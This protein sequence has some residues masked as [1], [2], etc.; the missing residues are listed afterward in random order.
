[1]SE[2][3][4]SGKYEFGVTYQVKLLRLIS[5]SKEF[6]TS[7]RPILNPRYFT[8]DV[9][10]DISRLQL[11]YFDSRREV[12]TVAAMEVAV[13]DMLAQDRQRQKKEAEFVK[14]LESIQNASLEEQSDVI[15]RAIAFAQESAVAL[16]LLES[17]DDVDRG[18][19]GSVIPRLREA[20]SVGQDL[21]NIGSIYFE[22]KDRFSWSRNAVSV[23]TGLETL[24]RHLDGGLATHELGVIVG[25][26][27]AF[28][29]GTLQNLCASAL[30]QGCLCAYATLELQTFAVEKRMDK[31]LSRKFKGL[32][33]ELLRNEAYLEK[34]QDY[35]RRVRANLVTNRWPPN[36]LTVNG[37]RAWLTLLKDRGLFGRSG[38][39]SVLFVDYAKLLKPEGRFEKDTAAV[40]SLYQGCIQIASEFDCAVWTAIQANRPAV[41]RQRGGGRGNSGAKLIHKDDLAEC[42]AVAADS[43]VIISINQDLDEKTD[44]KMRLF[45][46]KVREAED[47]RVIP[48]KVNWD[49][50]SISENT[51]SV[52]RARRHVSTAEEV[53][54]IV[55]HDSQN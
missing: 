36:T 21:N 50:F 49:T 22:N 18:D 8:D 42:F 34:L 40:Q 43:D 48:V 10:V 33:P 1:M 41:Q 3:P 44:N 31:I 52:A 17:V 9:L 27:G 38:K 4:R 37:L 39:K 19:F 54:E 20:M 7:Y 46:A 35:Q 16:A 47:G 15:D 5:T 2:V 55:R 24:D 32:P 12:P 28:K 14:A 13:K 51:L 29:S 45:L 53:M 6:L 26:P 30:D 25:G 11:D 23:K